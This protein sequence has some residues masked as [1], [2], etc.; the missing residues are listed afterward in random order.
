MFFSIST[1]YWK[2]IYAENLFH[3]TMKNRGVMFEEFKEHIPLSIELRVVPE[4]LSL[5]VI[6]EDYPLD[7]VQHLLHEGI[8]QDQASYQLLF[9]KQQIHPKMALGVASSFAFS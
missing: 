6:L 3:M 5:V 4:K 1:E 8:L 2:R 9:A 7:Y